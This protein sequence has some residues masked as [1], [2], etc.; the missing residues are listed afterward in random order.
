M[1]FNEQ[2]IKEAIENV[3]I[4]T[5]ELTAEDVIEYPNIAAKLDTIRIRLNN[6]FEDSVNFD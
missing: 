1:N 4:I 5:G 6:I 3:L 2:S